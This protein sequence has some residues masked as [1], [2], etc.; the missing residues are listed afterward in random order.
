MPRAFSSWNKIAQ[1]QTI[2]ATLCTVLNSSLKNRTFSYAFNI[3]S[4]VHP[5][6]IAEIKSKAEVKTAEITTKLC[7]LFKT[8]DESVIEPA[9]KNIILNFREST[10]IYNIT[11][12][13]PNSFDKRSPA[14]VQALPAADVNQCNLTSILKIISDSE[15]L[16][17]EIDK[18]KIIGKD[19][20]KKEPAQDGFLKPDQFKNV[21]DVAS[22]LSALLSNQTIE[23]KTLPVAAH[24][25]IAKLLNETF[26]VTA[27][28]ESHLRSEFKILCTPGGTAKINLQYLRGMDTADKLLDFILLELGWCVHNSRLLTI[29]E[30]TKVS[31]YVRSLADPTISIQETLALDALCAIAP[32]DQFKKLVEPI[33]N[34]HVVATFQPLTL[35]TF[36]AEFVDEII[37][38]I[39]AKHILARDIGKL[40]EFQTLQ[41]FL[42]ENLQLFS[43]HPAVRAVARAYQAGEETQ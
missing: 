3:A 9:I 30:H 40:G 28:N 6:L 19:Y 7:T 17:A 27:V 43:R 23:G 16:T 8:Q 14:I 20:R 25:N 42:L 33:F 39:Y 21:N 26:L 32:V 35:Q 29:D 36:K 11:Y 13:P 31:E 4:A 12:F 10:M 22:R 24:S 5:L 38:R 34:D 2:A 37:K 1:Q 18:N 41:R 15:I